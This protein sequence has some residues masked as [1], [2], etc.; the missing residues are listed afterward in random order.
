MGRLLGSVGKNCRFRGFLNSV[1]GIRLAPIGIK[2]GFNSTFGYGI[3]VAVEG[4]AGQA[5]HLAGF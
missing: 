4:V 5:H 3:L 1:L 2:Q